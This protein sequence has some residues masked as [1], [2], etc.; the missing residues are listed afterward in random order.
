[1]GRSPEVRDQEAPGFPDE[2]EEKQHNN[3]SR[4]KANA[5][6]FIFEFGIKKVRR[7]LNKH[8]KATA[9]GEVYWECQIGFRWAWSDKDTPPADRMKTRDVLPSLQEQMIKTGEKY[10]LVV[11]SEGIAVSTETLTHMAGLLDWATRFRGAHSASNHL[12]S[13]LRAHGVMA[14]SLQQQNPSSRPMRIIP[15]PHVHEDT[16]DRSLCPGRG[17]HPRLGKILACAGV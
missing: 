15:V 12:L 10:T 5:Q 3:D 14:F 16:Q 11:D 4:K 1:M 2:V 17:P 7:V 6:Q 13:Y 8:N 9:M